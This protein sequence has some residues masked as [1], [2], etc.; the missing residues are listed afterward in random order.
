M[1][2]EIDGV[3]VESAGARVREEQLA[4]AAGSAGPARSGIRPVELQAVVEPGGSLHDRL[5]IAGRKVHI[6]C[7]HEYAAGGQ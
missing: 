4:R 5:C 3:V 1:G 7:C 2:L 6:G